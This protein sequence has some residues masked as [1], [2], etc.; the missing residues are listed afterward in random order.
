MF[1]QLNSKKFST[2]FTLFELIITVAIVAILT[3]LATSSYRTAMAKSDRSIAISDINDIALTLA[4]FYSSNR[5]YTSDFK[6]LNMASS[7]Q[8]TLSDAQQYYVYTL[9]IQNSG[10]DYIIEAQPNVKSR[11]V[12]NLRLTDKGVKTSKLKTATTWDN[13]WP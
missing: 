8:S 3:T 1:N 11:D 7:T 13:G 10:E 12:W 6:D 2:G 9:S 5:S 4:R